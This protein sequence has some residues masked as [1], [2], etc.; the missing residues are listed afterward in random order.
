MT[1]I[2]NDDAQTARNNFGE[3]PNHAD[4]IDELKFGCRF[5]DL[6]NLAFVHEPTIASTEMYR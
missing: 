1:A 3:P 4:R 6:G 2:K 5:S